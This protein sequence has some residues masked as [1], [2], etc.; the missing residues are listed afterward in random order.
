MGK[1]PIARL[2]M[3]GGLVAAL[4]GPV[5]WAA[6]PAQ[7]ATGGGECQL[8]GTAHFD[9]P[10]LT[11]TGGSFTYNFS[12]ALSSCNSNVSGAPTSGTVAA[13]AAY[14]VT[15]SGTDTSGPW[16]VTYALPESTG[17]GGCAQSQTQGVSIAT[18]SNGT[19]IVDYTTTGAAA[20]VE[21]QGTVA[22]TAT[23]VEVSSTGTPPT[24]TPTTDTVGS[25]SPSFPVGDGVVG[26]LAFS[27]TTPQACQTGLS[28]AGI[29]GAVGLGSAS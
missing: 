12:G 18:W 27:T 22:S 16:S 8:A 25:T 3:I 2:A 20:A 5:S 11:A 19:T 29:S 24:G 10:G 6:A 23:L 21:L 1:R 15:S 13:G 26:Q 4:A 7:A 14:T 9:P 17:T 28:T